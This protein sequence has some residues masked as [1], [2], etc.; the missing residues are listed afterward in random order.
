MNIQSNDKLDYL[1]IDNNIKNSIFVSIN[2][3]K[4]SRKRNT[5][6]KKIKL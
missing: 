3:G 1:D 4:K 6:S 2:G 5:I